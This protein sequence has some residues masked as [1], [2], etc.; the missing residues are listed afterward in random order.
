MGHFPFNTISEIPPACWN[1]TFRRERSDDCKYVWLL[2]LLVKVG[3]K[4]T[5]LGTTILSNGKGHFGPTDRDNRS[6]QGGPPSKLVPNI[7]V[8]PNRNGPF[9][10][11]YQP[12]FPECWVEWK[13]PMGSNVQR[14]SVWE[15]FKKEKCWARESTA[16]SPKKDGKC[17][18]TRVRHSHHMRLKLMYS[19]KLQSVIGIESAHVRRNPTWNRTCQHFVAEDSHSKQRN[20]KSQSSVKLT[21]TRTPSE[22]LSKSDFRLTEKSN[23]GSKESQGPILGGRLYKSVR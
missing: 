23:E 1:G 4:R 17:V 21:L 16:I 6:G 9:H 10:L 20:F 11:M 7:P 22:P 18:Y 5:L 19:C 15:T 12:K 3:Y 13:A 2:F 8:G 14:A